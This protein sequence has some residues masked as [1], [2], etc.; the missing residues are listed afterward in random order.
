[1]LLMCAA[2]RPSNAAGFIT[3]T[4]VVVDEGGAPVADAVV[5]VNPISG[6]AVGIV[7]SDAAGNFALYDLELSGDYDVVA[8]AEQRNATGDVERTF[9]AAD[10]GTTVSLRIVVHTPEATRGLGEAH[11]WTTVRVHYATDRQA[12][13][14]TDPVTFFANAEADPLRMSFGSADVSI[15]W[16]HKTGMMESLTVSDYLRFDFKPDSSK[17]IVLLRVTPSDEN[18]LFGDI[19]AD[20]KFERAKQIVVYIHGYRTSFD[21]AVRTAA[22]IKYDLL[23]VPLA[24]VA[25]SWP[26][27]SA[28]LS[29]FDDL[30][31]SQK[32]STIHDLQAFLTELVR[33][34]PG[35]KVSVIA[36]S[37]GNRVL[38]GA[39]L[40][41]AQDAN[42]KEPAFD[43]VIMAAPDIPSETITQNACR[44]AAQDH[45]LT[46]YASQ[47]DQA[48]RA[49][50]T[51]SRFAR[52]GFG[53]PLLVTAGVD[54]IDAT[55]AA[56]DLIG[57]GYFAHDASIL[58]DIDQVLDD[59]PPPRTHL[60]TRRLGSAPY[61]EFEEKPPPSG[62]PTVQ[63]NRC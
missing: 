5:T 63:T 13:G 8:A 54:T 17:H 62:T 51:V 15:P 60:E 44:L 49:A 27:R 41:M 9:T 25:Y 61:W 12:T 29:Y 47:H 50:E 1:L 4:G 56:T 32:S 34:N 19:R 18:A 10:D 42:V 57:H 55:N 20:A 30:T 6:N 46:L 37:M 23:P 39:M 43:Q 38:V 33:R 35:T 40:A 45:G 53:D 31:E 7:T 14:S 22:Q 36:H 58:A 21:D 24:V 16:T 2:P 11:P 26:S 59:R 52:A 48:L 28:L 3:I